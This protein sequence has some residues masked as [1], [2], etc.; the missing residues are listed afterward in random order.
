[1]KKGPK[2]FSDLAKYISEIYANVEGKN[3]PSLTLFNFAKTLISSS[4]NMIFKNSAILILKTMY[5]FHSAIVE[6]DIKDL[7]PQLIKT[8]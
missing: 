4:T 5:K 7:N 2:I 6:R 8:L 3:M 1:M